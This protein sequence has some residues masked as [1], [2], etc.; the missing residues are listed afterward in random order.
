MLTGG[1]LLALQSPRA[2]AEVLVKSAR[3]AWRKWKAWNVD[4]VD[5][6]SIAYSPIMRPSF[7]LAFTEDEQRYYLAKY[8]T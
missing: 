5:V 2:E 8:S 6:K 1:R 4:V 3:Y 7:P